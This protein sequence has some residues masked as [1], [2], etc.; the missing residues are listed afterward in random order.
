MARH[1]LRLAV[2]LCDGQIGKRR[3]GAYH[4]DG[5]VVRIR[6]GNAC[7][8][9]HR[10]GI[11]ERLVKRKI[12]ICRRGN[13]E[14]CRAE[15][16]QI[17]GRIDR[18]RSRCWPGRS[19]AV[20]RR[21]G[22]A[23]KAC[24]QRVD[25]RGPGHRGRALVACGDDVED[26]TAG[27]EFGLATLRDEEIG[28]RGRG[29]PD[30]VGRRERQA[31][32][33]SRGSHVGRVRDHRAVGDPGV[34]DHIKLNNV[35]VGSRCQ[36]AADRRAGATSGTGAE[37]KL[38]G[39]RAADVFALIGIDRVG[40][41]AGIG[42]LPDAKRSRLEC[43]VGRHHVGEDDVGGRLLERRRNAG[44]A[45]VDDDKIP[46][47]VTGLHKAAVEI[48]HLF[49]H[50]QIARIQ[51]RVDIGSRVVARIGIGQAGGIRDGDGVREIAKRAGPDR[52][53]DRE[54]GR[55]AV[56]EIDEAVD[57]AAAGGGACRPRAVYGS[58]RGSL[59]L[60]GER[61]DDRRSSHVARPVVGDD[62]CVGGGRAGYVLRFPVGL[63]DGQIG[64]PLRCDIGKA[65]GFE[66]ESGD[67]PCVADVGRIFDERQWCN[68]GVHCHLKCDRGRLPGSQ[69]AAAGAIATGTGAELKLH[70]TCA[71]EKLRLIAVRGVGFAAN[72]HAGC[73]VQG[74]GL[75]GR[76]GRDRIFQKH[77][78]RTVKRSGAVGDNHRVRE[79]VTSD[80]LATILVL[81]TLHDRNLRGK[82][83]N[84]AGHYA[85]VIGF[86]AG[87][88]R[89][90]GRR[91]PV[92]DDAIGRDEVGIV[93]ELIDVV[94]VFCGDQCAAIRDRAI[95]EITG[96]VGGIRERPPVKCDAVSG[97]LEVALIG[98]KSQRGLHQSSRG[99]LKSRNGDIHR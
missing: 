23:R 24:G 25:D 68:T 90:R 46:Q 97:L 43:R 81:D 74:T 22:R 84:G 37:L 3:G 44:R 30:R 89:D 26:R 57:L 51:K 78:D 34:H 86:A 94:G 59:N 18:P 52:R 83:I 99:C 31:R 27:C 33:G 5:I 61:V 98:N 72:I 56:Q 13:A 79:H 11:G 42:S 29:D 6:V 73:D 14:N 85:G 63:C 40:F 54:R 7:R 76:V 53:R 15:N 82:N 21:P 8:T 28:R 87:C 47:H 88:H 92:F 45:A 1:V 65:G 77:V 2:S 12:S 4:S 67:S 36:R 50:P 95:E 91:G 16:G 32:R 62:D 20:G 75:V 70:G 41:D 48:G 38:H 19:A 71:A 64:S 93:A 96:W 9:G 58:P 80:H 55:A 35:R 39:V 49:R 10:G 66:L 69:S 17:D 60:A